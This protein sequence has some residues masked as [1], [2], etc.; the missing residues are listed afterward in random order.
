M[1]TPKS[2]LL[3]CL[4]LLQVSLFAQV[5]WY[6]SQNGN[7]VPP[8]GTFGSCSKAFTPTSFVACYQ[9]EINNESYTWKISKTHYNG[10]EQKTFF[11]TGTWASVE[12]RTGNANSLYVLLRSFPIWQDAEFTVYKLDSNLV[13]K[14]Q[15][16]IS[17]D[18]AFSIFNLNNIELDQSD[19]VYVTGDGQ[20]INGMDV[21]PASFVMKTDRNLRTKWARIDSTAT[22]YNSILFDPFDRP[23]V[24]EDRYMS[25][26]EVRIN[27]FSANGGLI[28]T[29]SIQGD[30]AR[31]NL[32]ANMDDLGNIYFYGGKMIGDTAQGMYLSKLN[33]ANT[34]M[35]YNK[36]FF[37]A[38]GFQLCDIK[39]DHDGNIFNIVSQY[40]G[41]GGM[42]CV[43]SRI[44]SYNGNIS[45]SQVHA[46]SN[47]SCNLVKLVMNGSD[48]FY[49]IGEKRANGFLSKGLVLR[50]KKN[51][52]Q[53]GVYLGP[54]S[55]SSQLSHTLIDGVSGRNDQLIAIGNTNDFDPFTFNS[56]YYRA[57]AISF[58]QRNEHHNCD[59]KG[60]EETA[61]FAGKGTAAA[62]DETIE[63]ARL[64][65]FPNP[66]QDQLTVTQL[67]A[68]EYDRI[69]IYD[70]HG[71]G[72]IH[73]SMK[74]TAARIDVSGLANGM[75]VLTLQSSRSLIQK[76]LKFV[77]RK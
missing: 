22:T 54:D 37:D 3:P 13:V 41:S 4:L 77:V 42:Q 72:V 46:F 10:T 35:A 70:M 7:N 15:K 29:R 53:E 34:N 68:D 59:G 58:G 48:K 39:F 31:F 16:R 2:L 64:S 62:T 40:T 18:G 6:Q 61:S 14:A 50:M 75:Y 11:V 17:L 24:V 73:Q 51:G 55:T 8:N 5:Q 49:V 19:N 23:V 30:P 44:N 60:T 32:F 12:M 52:Q 27:R 71:V 65:V 9:W 33:R 38:V 57:F 43:V 45:W 63:T 26:P 1:K 25:F 66:V 28:S 20:Y 69:T 76:D 47:D 36:T 67:N 74:G 21:L 56:S